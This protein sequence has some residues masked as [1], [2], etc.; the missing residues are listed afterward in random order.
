MFAISR[1]RKHI[2]LSIVDKISL[3]KA[4]QGTSA[5]S[6]YKTYSIEKSTV[7]DILKQKEKF[8]FFAVSELPASMGKKQNKTVNC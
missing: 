3:L 7:Y 6:R 2:L 4:N 1:K 5:I 8:Q